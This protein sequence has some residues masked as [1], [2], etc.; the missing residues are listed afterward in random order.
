MPGSIINKAKSLSVLGALI[1]SIAAS[2][3]SAALITQN[4]FDGGDAFQSTNSL[5][6][7][8]GDTFTL[9]G[10]STV[11]GFGWWG[12]EVADTT[13]FVVRLFASLGGSAVPVF[14]CGFDLVACDGS[15]RQFS[16]VLSDSGPN[17]L[18]GFALDLTSTLSL[19]GGSYLLSIS[20]EEEE[21]YWSSTTE[22][23]GLSFIRG[24]DA[25]AWNETQPGLAFT[26]L[27]SRDTTSVPE[28]GTLALLGLGGL[29]AL[30]LRRRKQTA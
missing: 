19:V 23:D 8:N 15:V 13:G 1:C 30:M 4:P 22:G 5:G 16:T 3:A 27:G 21:W 11:T 6:L 7:Q 25:D 18:S 9:G 12:S 29:S 10:S 17:P 20:H 2:S 14:S 28:P 24:D 26:V